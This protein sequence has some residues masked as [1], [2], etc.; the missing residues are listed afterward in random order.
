MNI[1]TRFI[2]SHVSMSPMSISLSSPLCLSFSLLPFLSFILF[3]F[4]TLHC[5]FVLHSGFRFL[6]SRASSALVYV[7]ALQLDLFSSVSHFGLVTPGYR[8]QSIVHFA[9][10]HDS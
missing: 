2:H 7:F 1:M 8:K 3:F 6:F 5:F 4:F 9:G 10:V